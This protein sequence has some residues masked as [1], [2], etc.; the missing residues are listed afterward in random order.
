[1]ADEQATKRTGQ[2]GQIAQT[3]PGTLARVPAP[4]LTHDQAAYL[5]ELRQKETDFDATVIIGRPR[6]HSA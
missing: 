2:T 3:A 1:M 5:R 4:T 6:H